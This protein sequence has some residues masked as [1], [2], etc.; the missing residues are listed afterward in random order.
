MTRI[1]CVH[2]IGQQ[3]ESRETLFDTWAPAL[4][5][6]VSNAGGT[7]DRAEITMAFYGLM[8][9]PP[10]GTKGADT[11]PEYASGDLSEFERELLGDIYDG[12]LA[13]E[14]PSRETKGGL[15]R[16]VAGM[17]QVVGR[18]P[19]FGRVAQKFVIWHL[20]QVSRYV[21]DPAT[22]S[23]ARASVLQAIA[24]DT[25]VLLAH[26]LGSIVAWEVLCAN[27]GLTVRTF[28]TIGSPLGLPALRRRLDP[29]IAKVPG[30]WP[31]G[32]TRWVNIADAKDAVALEK[33]LA[34]VFG[35]RVEDVPVENGATMHNVRPYLTSVD[36]GRAII[37]GLA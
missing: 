10:G 2:G 25:R 20:K 21:S 33:R 13:L 28:I 12:S 27:P 35:A 34:R 18:T 4:T 22:R 37:A 29:A 15:T 8:F 24:D 5:G 19:F 7:L 17:L 3:Y 26:S 6:G 36:V 14:D 30:T 11:V 9:R 1:V 23:S 31:P 16:S 32:I